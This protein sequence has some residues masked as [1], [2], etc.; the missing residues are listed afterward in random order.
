M[1]MRLARCLVLAVAAFASLATS[2]PT[3][4]PEPDECDNPD[5]IALTTLELGG[6]QSAFSP[7]VPGDP[8]FIT[9]G[10]QGLPMVGLKLRMT[11]PT[12]IACLAKHVTITWGDGSTSENDVPVNVYA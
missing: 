7:Y 1:L 12:P 3:P 4:A 2:S 11:A 9:Q 10:G 8:I 6:P 5:A